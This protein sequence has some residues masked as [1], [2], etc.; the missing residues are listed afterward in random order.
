MEII[1]NIFNKKQLELDSS[2][3]MFWDWFRCNSIV[4]AEVVHQHNRIEED[5]LDIVLPKLRKINEDFTILVGV[6]ELEE[7]EMIITPDGQAKSIPYVEELIAKAPK[8]EGWNFIGCKPGTLNG[9]IEMNGFVL[10]EDTVSFVPVHFEE[11]PDYIYL[12]FVVDGFTPEKEDE[13]GNAM[14]IFLD[15]YIGELATM[16]LVDDIQVCGND[17]V[18]GDLIPISKLTGY[19]KFREAEFVEK[20]DGVLHNSE[21]DSFG[22]LQGGEGESRVIIVVN[23]TFLNWERKMSYPWTVTV[24]LK[25]EGRGDGLPTRE[26]LSKLEEIEDLLVETG[27]VYNVGRKTGE[28]KR[29]LYLATKDFR[30]ASKE[31]NAVLDLF[32]EELEVEYFVYKDKYWKHLESYIN[33]VNNS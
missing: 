15:N 10:N 27:T 23:K 6:N 22:I 26:G 25:Y 29:V 21:Q 19:L 30:K 28:N 31:V 32:S 18:E 13:I 4:L 5:F 3:E 2:Y 16:T 17:D 33:V 24:V 20:Y 9:G 14:Y 8:I 12:R 7:A 11:Y 1:K